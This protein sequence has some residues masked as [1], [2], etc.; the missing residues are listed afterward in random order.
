MSGQALLEFHSA[1]NPGLPD[2]DHSG[3]SANRDQLQRHAG[4]P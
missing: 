2:C 1:K 4:R 3:R